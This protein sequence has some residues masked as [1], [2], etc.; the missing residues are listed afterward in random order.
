MSEL[1]VCAPAM[2]AIKAKAAT[3]AP[4]F[5]MMS[6]EWKAAQRTAFVTVLR[7]RVQTRQR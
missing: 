7:Y 1:P 2:A 4:S 5:N 6:P 3:A